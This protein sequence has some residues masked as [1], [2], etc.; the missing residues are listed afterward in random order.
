MFEKNG[1]MTDARRQLMRDM[2]RYAAGVACRHRHL[3]GYFGETYAK[4]DCGACDYCLGELDAVGEPVTLARKILSAVARVGQRFGAGH[5][6][7][8]LRGSDTGLVA[9]RGHS[10]L[11]VFGLLAGAT[12]DEI[13]GYIDQLVA[14]EL[15][16]QSPRGRG[17][18]RGGLQLPQRPGGR[19]RPGADR[20]R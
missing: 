8:V 7:N 14:Q 4:T 9:S 10:A 15:L 6:A 3:V 13:R 11:S 12:V 16:R 2:E 5:V 18:G 1:E 20:R 17:A 19:R